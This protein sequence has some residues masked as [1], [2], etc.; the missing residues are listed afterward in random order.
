MGPPT[1]GAADQVV[2]LLRGQ[3]P[4]AGAGDSAWEEK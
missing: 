1:V 4:G 2:L 3:P